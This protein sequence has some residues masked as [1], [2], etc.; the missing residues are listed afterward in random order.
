MAAPSREEL[1]D[2]VYAEARLLDTGRY[3]EWYALFA[4]EGLYWVPLVPDQADAIHHNSLAYE[5]RLLLRL[6]IERL[7]D[8]GPFS[9]HP[10]SR[11]H[12]LL[13][14][15]EVESA[16]PV[17]NTYVIRTPFHYTETRGNE[18]VVLVGTVYHY[19]AL[20]NGRLAIMLKRVNILNSDAALPSIQLFL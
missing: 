3:E 8:P 15:P 14:R 11:C 20:R 9:Q 17:A 18:Q 1:I 4:E 12:H 13:Q 16:D 5:D 7:R 6:R 2:F 19:L 10:R